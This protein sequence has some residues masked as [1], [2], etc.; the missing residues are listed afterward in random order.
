MGKSTQKCLGKMLCLSWAPTMSSTPPHRKSRDVLFGACQ[1][2]RCGRQRRSSSANVPWE[3]ATQTWKTLYSSRRTQK[4]F[5]E[6]QRKLPKGFRLVCA[7][8]SL[9]V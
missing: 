5:S 3:A 6:T 4:C 7:N 1:Y 2:L 8:D 9:K